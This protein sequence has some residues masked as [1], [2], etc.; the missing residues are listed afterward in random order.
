[1][2]AVERRVAITRDGCKSGV[3][4]GDRARRAVSADEHEL[5]PCDGSSP[6]AIPVQPL[7]IQPLVAATKG[8]ERVRDP[9]A[10]ARRLHLL[11][12]DWV[13]EYDST[14][15]CRAGRESAAAEVGRCPN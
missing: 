8:V 14:R 6:D 4:G 1:M 11:G 15:A 7:E 12:E 3:T 5:R 10:A 2:H 9:D 13:G